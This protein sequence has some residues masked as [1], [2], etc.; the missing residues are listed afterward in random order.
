MLEKRK[1]DWAGKVRIVGL[2]I[3]QSKDVVVQHVDN[4]KWT[5]VEHYHRHES[6]FNDVY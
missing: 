4:K 1:D 2:S 5:S 6:D 3:D